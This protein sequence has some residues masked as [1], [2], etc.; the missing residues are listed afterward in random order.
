MLAFKGPAQPSPN[1]GDALNEGYTYLEVCCLGCDTH[2]TAALD[3]V[4]RPKATPIHELDRY[5]CVVMRMSGAIWWRCGG[6]DFRE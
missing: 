1:L 2:R 4:R 6:Q 5:R 3:I